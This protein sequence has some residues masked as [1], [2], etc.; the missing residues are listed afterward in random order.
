MSAFGPYA[1]EQTVDFTKMG[2]SGLYLI[3]G[4]TGAGKTTIFDAITYAL[5]GEASGSERNDPSLLRSKYAQMQTPTFVELEFLY[6]GEAY[7]VRRN[8]A[9]ERAKTRGEGTTLQKADAELYFPDGRTPVTKAKEVTAAIT[10]LI[11]L[12]RKQFTQIAM[13]AQGDF[14]KLLLADTQERSL[15][16]REIFHTE[17]F[18]VLQERLRD[19]ANS[20]YRMLHETGLRMRQLLPEIELGDRH[21][22]VLE[23]IL[24]ESG[25]K[26]GKEALLRDEQVTKVLEDLSLWI[27][28]DSARIAEAAAQEQVLQKQLEEKDRRIGRA[29]FVEDLFRQLAESRKEETMLRARREAA[30]KES[31]KQKE[32]LPQREQLNEEAIRLRGETE[33]YKELLEQTREIGMRRRS[34]AESRAEA[35]KLGKRLSQMREQISQMQKEIQDRK[36]ADSLAASLEQKQILLQRRKEEANRLSKEIEHF[37]SERNRLVEKQSAY[38][39]ADK[40]YQADRQYYEDLQ[41]SF[42]DAQA[43]ILAQDLEEGIECPVCGAVHHPK[44]AQLQNSVPDEQTVRAAK[45]KA[46]GSDTL[47]RQCAEE[48]A[49]LRSGIKVIF[50][51]ILQ[52]TENFPEDGISSAA[53][54]GSKWSTLAQQ[55]R[56][57]N[58]LTA[59][60]KESVERYHLLLAEEIRG[61]EDARVKAQEQA[62][63]SLKLQQKTEKLQK[64]EETLQ[65]RITDLQMKEA[66]EQTAAESLEKQLTERRKSLRFESFEEAS[67]HLRELGKKIKEIDLATG[68][69]EKE[70]RE[71][72]R[73][74]AENATKIETLLHNL[75]ETLQGREENF[76][77]ES[78]DAAEESGALEARK[79]YEVWQGML[80]RDREERDRLAEE[81]MR[82]QRQ[83]QMLHHRNLTDKRIH[84][85]LTRTAALAKKTESRYRWLSSL[86]ATANGML[87]G[88]EK[89][90]LET[91]VQMSYFDRI[92]ARAN[93]RLMTMSG[94]HYDL[95][96]RREAENQRSRS[97]LELNVIDHYNGSQRSVRTLSGGETFLASLSLALG[98]ADEIQ[99]S[100]GGIRLETMFVDEG[101]GSLDNESLQMAMQA[102]GGLGEGKRL[103]GIISHVNELKERIDRK[104]IVARKKDG[105]STVRYE[106]DL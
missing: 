16:F 101:F 50:A 83:G 88:K 76:D 60:F 13:I 63:H 102:L 69:A 105:S 46:D 28:E 73:R 94:G 30:E 97:G 77:I 2:E 7:K 43:G 6:R 12:D 82:L 61:T 99:E 24:R 20:V 65:T 37:M 18:S 100:A 21:S 86:S 78:L 96:R 72:E 22:E 62:Q 10:E 75:R 35:E 59:P 49:A 74:S 31:E 14:R 64:D 9:Y 51:N 42:L 95:V 39:S 26:S 34:A 98:L 27:S 38:R 47:R 32:Q 87:S 92:I 81:R 52:Q 23:E 53:C 85:E 29:R 70:Y 48:F 80:L 56:E 103:V 25:G 11:G 104:L 58:G 106:T 19:E 4:D 15:I 84:E 3:T 90:T 36:G 44:P 68:R 66:K 67:A 8:P 45:K 79:Q 89:L 55:A 17:K 71:A 57:Q 41:K 40:Q 33:L 91:Y 54:S 93:V 1:G 5:Y